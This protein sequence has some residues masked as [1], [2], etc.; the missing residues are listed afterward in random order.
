MSDVRTVGHDE[1]AFATVG[2]TELLRA[3]ESDRNAATQSLQCWDEVGEL[4]VGIPRHVLAEETTSP[5]A[6]KGVDD[7]IG[8]PSF[9]G[10]AK[11]ASGDA[12]GLAGVA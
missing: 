9:V 3:E 6:V 4:P 5:A 11:A 1:H 7:A 8:K 12:V 10:I 2:E